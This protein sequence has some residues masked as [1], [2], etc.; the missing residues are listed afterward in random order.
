MRIKCTHKLRRVATYDTKYRPLHI[1]VNGLCFANFDVAVR[2]PN[3]AEK[4]NLSLPYTTQ[5]KE[6][7]AAVTF[8]NGK[9][10]GGG[11]GEGEAEFAT[12]KNYRE[13]GVA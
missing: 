12:R 3:F 9:R 7:F 13:Q 1:H 10:R 8:E 6:L 5:M 4:T 2:H 11:G